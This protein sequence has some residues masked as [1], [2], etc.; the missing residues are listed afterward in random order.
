MNE[1]SPDRIELA[2]R[3]RGWTKKELAERADMTPTHIGRLIG[4][5]SSG[6]CH[7]P[8]NVLLHAERQWHGRRE[9]RV[10]KKEADHQES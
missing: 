4:G 6:L 3:Y 9:T 10:Q 7:Q 8:P 2:R 5:P 1:F